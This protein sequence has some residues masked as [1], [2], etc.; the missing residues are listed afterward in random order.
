[1]RRSDAPLPGAGNSIGADGARALAE[2]AAGGAFASLTQLYLHSA[3]W[4]GLGVVP[5][6]QWLG[7]A[8]EGGLGCAAVLRRFG[9][10][11]AMRWS[12]VECGE[13]T[14]RCWR[15]TTGSAPMARAR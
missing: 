5:I 6:A 10:G 13:V 7:G 15:Q 1:M 11:N 4:C 12:G 14:R 2:A 3:W 8:G 9:A